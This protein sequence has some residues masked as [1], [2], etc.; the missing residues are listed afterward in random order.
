M[1]IPKKG[2]IIPIM[3]MKSTSLGEVLFTKT[4]RRVLG[5]LFGNP[6]RSYYANE[7][8][9]FA[10]VGIGAVQ[11]ELERLESSQLL[12]TT[13]IGNQKH[14]QANRSAPI[15]E[16]LSGIVL[17]TFGVA[18]HLRKALSPL[19]KRIRAAFIYGS[20]ARD[21]DKA[22]SDIDVMI[23]SDDLSYVEVLKVFSKTQ[24]NVQRPINPVV[25]SLGE[26][27]RKSSEDGGFVNRVVDQPKIFL[28]GSD[29]DLV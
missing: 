2:T 17:K 22:Q 26:W 11:R 1:F 3:G 20:V 14:Y 18:D 7:I 16:E 5:L 4:Q 29:D 13:R 27:R 10:G 8:V 6:D 24:T 9:R 23:I 21:T 28:I 25:F 19:K 12:T 15:F